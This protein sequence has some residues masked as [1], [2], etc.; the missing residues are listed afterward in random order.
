MSMFSVW[1]A[2]LRSYWKVAMS[3]LK[4]ILSGTA[5]TSLRGIAA[6]AETRRVLF[7]RRA[8]KMQLRTSWI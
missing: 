5:T 7:L 1:K 6:R 2:D 3:Y 4:K 8:T